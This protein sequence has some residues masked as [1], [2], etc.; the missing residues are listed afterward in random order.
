[1]DCQQLKQGMVRY[2]VY[3]YSTSSPGLNLTP[4]GAFSRV[5]PSAASLRSAKNVKKMQE[6]SDSNQDYTTSRL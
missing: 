2:H 4:L 1:M 5:L 6:A 3:V